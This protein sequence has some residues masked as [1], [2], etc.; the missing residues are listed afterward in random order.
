[1]LVSILMGA[2]IFLFL[3]SDAPLHPTNVNWMYA[4]GG[5]LLQQQS[6][7]MA[8]RSEPWSGQIGVIANY[9]DQV[10]TSIVYSNMTPL[11]AVFFKLLDPL[12]PT[13]FQF[14][15]LWV[16]LCWILQIYFSIR[17]LAELNCSPWVRYGGAVLLG[18]SPVLIDRAF[19]HDPLCAQWLLLAGIWLL[20][21]AIHHK[22][23]FKFWPVLLLLSVWIHAYIFFMLLFLF[24][25]ATGDSS[26]IR[27]PLEGYRRP[28]CCCPLD[29]ALAS[30]YLLGMFNISPQMEMADIRNYSVNLNTWIN[31]GKSSAFF[32]QLGL[33]FDGQYEGF[34]Y[35][36][37]GGFLLVA[38]A[39]LA[40]N[41]FSTVWKAR[42][43][44]LWML[45]PVLLMALLATGGA[46]T[47]GKQ[48][49]FSLNLPGA[50]TDLLSV[51]RS[52]GRFIWPLYYLVLLSALAV[53]DRRAVSK[54][55]L[56][57]LL[58]IQVVD[59]APLRSQK[60]YVRETEY[61]SPLVSAF[62]TTDAPTF[63]HL[64]F[65]PD[66]AIEARLYRSC[67]L[68]SSAWINSQLGVSCP[69]RL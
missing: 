50:V 66:T 67:N 52:L 69:R 23:G 68:R 28:F 16:L 36:G 9:P 6:G 54:A 24:A 47:W 2:V 62:W 3:F 13:V 8:Y 64:V 31:P 22:T 18:L 26:A 48:V 35:P 34:A 49:L 51:V 39:I 4:R 25:G 27:S 17:V 46:L 55:W 45:I 61:R 38:T 7:W 44:Y 40:W 21:R 37:L 53:F 60:S 11:P 57:A 1:M 32:K 30:A 19:H 58:I 56:L 5:D 41:Y 65:L 33:A 15:G 43:T 12:L 42:Q 14:T 63:D 10:S 59:L 20:I 29:Y